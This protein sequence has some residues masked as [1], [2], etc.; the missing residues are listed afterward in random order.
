MPRS[1]FDYDPEKDKLPAMATFWIIVAALGAAVYLS[2]I[3]V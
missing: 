2:I 3:L 1:E